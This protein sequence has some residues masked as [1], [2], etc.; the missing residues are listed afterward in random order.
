MAGA[1][2]GHAPVKYKYTRAEL[3]KRGSNYKIP[4]IRFLGDGD[5][6]E[7]QE[8][9]EGESIPLEEL[10]FGGAERPDAPTSFFRSWDYNGRAVIHA[11]RKPMFP[12][13]RWVEEGLSH[14]MNSDGEMEYSPYRVDTTGSVWE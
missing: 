5:D 8:H 2:T 12:D 10:G 1:T 7:M 14:T 9:V 6:I 4:A 3:E 11:V 13:D